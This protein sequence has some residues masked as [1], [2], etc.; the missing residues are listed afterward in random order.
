MV[1]N[2]NPLTFWNRIRME[3]V[4]LFLRLSPKESLFNLFVLACR[5]A[6]FGIVGEVCVVVVEGE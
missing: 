1:N 2:S 6:D 4:V 3:S 5:F